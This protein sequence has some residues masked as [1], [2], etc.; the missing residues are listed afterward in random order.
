M[1]FLSFFLDSIRNDL[2]K[3]YYKH[4]MTKLTI[5]N[6]KIPNRNWLKLEKSCTATPRLSFFLWLQKLKSNHYYKIIQKKRRPRNITLYV[7]TFCSGSNP[8]SSWWPG[9]FRYLIIYTLVHANYTNSNN[10]I[11]TFATRCQQIPFCWEH[12]T[13]NHYEDKLQN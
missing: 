3:T 6:Q 5:Q 12:Q 7:E 4:C 8:Y 9:L 11:D 2:L 10:N 1:L 13:E